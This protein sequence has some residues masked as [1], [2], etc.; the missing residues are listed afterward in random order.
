[1]YH[2]GFIRHIADY[3]GIQLPRLL[4][5]SRIAQA[6]H[7]DEELAGQPVACTQ[8]ESFRVAYI[9][10]RLLRPKPVEH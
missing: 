7:R 2:L 10:Y 3:E 9:V 5:L 6:M 1:V 8:E 4:Q